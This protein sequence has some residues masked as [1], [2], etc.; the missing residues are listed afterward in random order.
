MSDLLET[1]SDGHKPKSLGM[2]CV[3]K[4]PPSDNHK[5][6]CRNLKNNAGTAARTLYKRCRHCVQCFGWLTEK[7]VDRAE[8]QEYIEHRKRSLLNRYVWMKA[9]EY[10]YK[11]SR[12]W[13]T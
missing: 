6:R 10:G 9:E 13:A 8:K 12:P 11:K 4:L 1:P 2:E 5:V 3:L 7:R